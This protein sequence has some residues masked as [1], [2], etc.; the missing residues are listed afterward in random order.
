RRRGAAEMAL[1]LDRRRLGISL[2][3]DQSTQICAM[4]A[5]HLLPRWLA[6]VR[7]EIDLALGLE[8]IQKNS[9][10][11]LRHLDE[12]E[13]RPAFVIDTNR[14]AQVD[15]VE[16]RA[17]GTHLAPPIEERRLPM[18]ERALQHAVIAQADVV[19]DLFA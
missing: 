19:R 15:V 6:L 14:G 10:P 13:V 1:L 2:R 3:H 11:I 8:R 7:A 18:L 9:P 12:V 5:R 4:L 16:A 17:V